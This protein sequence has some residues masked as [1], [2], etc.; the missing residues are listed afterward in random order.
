MWRNVLMVLGGYLVGSL[1]FAYFLGKIHG[2]D[3][4]ELGSGNAGGS[5]AL[6]IYGKKAGFIVIILDMLKAFIMVTLAKE[7]FPDPY[8]CCFTADAVILGHMFPFYMH[9]RGGKGLACL[10]GSIIALSPLL[11]LILLLVELALLFIIDYIIVL[12]LTLTVMFPPL[13]AV[14]IQNPY[15]LFILLIPAIPIW[16]RHIP[17]LR[18]IKEGKEPHCLKFLRHADEEIERTTGGPDPR[19]K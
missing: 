6:I 18:R 4:R 7:L 2:H 10:G 13:Y 17:N 1:N 19:K 11:A 16:I 15:V 9:F 3:I 12:P 8:T 5:N 14:R